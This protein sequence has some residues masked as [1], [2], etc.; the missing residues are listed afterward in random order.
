MKWLALIVALVLVLLI[1]S[2]AIADDADKAQVGSKTTFAVS[3]IDLDGDPLSYDASNLPAGAIFDPITRVFSWTPNYAQ[4]GVYVIRFTVSDG[5]LSDYE[6]VTITVIQPYPDWDVN[7]DGSTNILDLI[8]VAQRFGETG[9]IGW[10]KEDANEDGV[11]NVLDL[12][13]ISN[14]L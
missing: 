1:P 8:A 4:E 11:V 3:A 6:D 5:E 13:L 9:T 10:T 12:I 2:S 7:W 14:H